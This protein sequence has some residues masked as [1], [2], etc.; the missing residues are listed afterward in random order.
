MGGNWNQNKVVWS[1]YNEVRNKI[2][3]SSL[4]CFRCSFFTIRSRVKNNSRGISVIIKSGENWWKLIKDGPQRRSDMIFSLIFSHIH[5]N[6]RHSAVCRESRRQA[7]QN[8]VQCAD[9]AVRQCVHPPTSL[10]SFSGHS[11][12]AQTR[13]LH[14]CDG[15]KSD[16]LTVMTRLQETAHSCCF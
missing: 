7:D 2:Q 8:R 13:P 10:C 6:M 4:G 1:V 14:R 12:G 3:K 16:N 9:F 15:I 11:T 5:M